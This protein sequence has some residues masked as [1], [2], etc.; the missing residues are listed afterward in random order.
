MEAAAYEEMFRLE[1]HHW[2]FRGRRRRTAPLVREAF[3]SLGPASVH[4]AVEVG[5]GTGGNLSHLLAHLPGVRAIGV[6]LDADALAF[7]RR[8]GLECGLVRADG[9]RLPL[10]TDSVDCLLASDIIEH[11]DDDSALL[12]ELAR[13]VRPGGQLVASVP[14][15]PSLWSPHD[16][17]LHHR[18]RYRSGELEARLEEA[19]FAVRRRLGFNFLLL[20]PIALVRAI[21]ARRSR[22]AGAPAAGTDFFEL[23]APL[24][25]ALGSL[26]AVESWIARVAPFPQGVS[27]LVRAERR[28]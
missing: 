28:P 5:C 23:P 11:F 20:P 6:D 12:R 10:A 9:C 13:V 18:R 26:F 27:L 14:Q 24:N 19:G 25:A 21:K 17:F 15:Y 16:E 2:W 7:S 3:E 1:D 22:R 8:R 4:T